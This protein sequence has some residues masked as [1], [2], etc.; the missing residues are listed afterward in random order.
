MKAKNWKNKKVFV[1]IIGLL[2][3]IVI[4]VA[5]MVFIFKMY[6]LKRLEK[7]SASDIINYITKEEDNIK[8]SIAVIQDGEVTYQV[9]GKNGSILTD[10]KYDYEI[11]S[12]SKTFVALMLSKA[13]EEDKINIKSSIHEYLELDKDKYYPTIEQLITHTSGYKSYYFNKQMISN[14]FHESNDFYGISKE[15]I[16]HKVKTIRLKDKDYKFK[17]SNFGISVI[18]LVLEKVYN[19]EF[20]PLMN[21]FITNDLKLEN[22]KVATCTGNL[23]GYWN[24]KKEDG[25]IPAGAIISNIEDMAKY[26]KLYMEQEEDYISNTYTKLKAIDANNFVYEK[27]N[28]RMDKVGMAWLIDEKNGFIWHNGGTSKFNSYIAFNKERNI[29]IVILGNISPTKKVPMTVLGVAL[30]KELS[31]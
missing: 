14:Y 31:K 26:L 1:K 17:Y 30:M 11:G 10:T 25:Y 22:T 7:M 9:Y 21:E 8:I 23:S 28:I 20:V 18:G 3:L 27:M 13:I 12:I 2:F 16:L 5:A 4:L 19:K 29:G 15:E 6:Q 24:W